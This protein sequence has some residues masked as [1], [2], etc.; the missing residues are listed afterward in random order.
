MIQTITLYQTVRYSEPRT[1]PIFAKGEPWLGEGY[2]FWEHEIE[3]AR[4]WG[5]THYHN[6]YSIYRSSYQNT[7]DGIDLVDNYEDRERL[8]KDY[9]DI[10]RRVSKLGRDKD[11]TL[12]EVIILMRK[13]VPKKFHYIRFESGTFFKDGKLQISVPNLR[14]PL[15]FTTQRLVQV[16]FPCFPC[17]EIGLTDYRKCEDRIDP[18]FG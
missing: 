7:E 17:Q 13:N 2:Y 9:Q 10:K 5:K 8:E 14:Y 15:T 3:N 1:S 16:C 11:V 6:S 18:V 4:Y 12:R